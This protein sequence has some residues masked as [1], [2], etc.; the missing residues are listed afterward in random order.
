MGNEPPFTVIAGKYESD[1]EIDVK[2]IDN[3]STLELA[4]E[5]FNERYDYPIR[6]IE[7]RF[8]QVIWQN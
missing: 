1:G 5:A 4:I 8:G 2:Y 3:F 7:D 6:Q